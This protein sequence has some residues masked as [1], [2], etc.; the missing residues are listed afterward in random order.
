MTMKKKILLL[1]GNS[2]INRAFYALPIL[3][4][5]DGTYTNAVYGFLNI[6]FKLFDEDKPD[7]A[8]V[9]FD[10]PAP[11][12]RHKQFGDY[13]GDRKPMPQEL[14]P[15]IGTLKN[16]LA[17]MNV[18][19][20]EMEGFEAD[21][22][23]GTLAAKSLG[24]GLAPVIV[25]GDRDMLQLCTDVLEVRIPRTKAGKTEVE[26]YFAQDVKERIGV[27]PTEYIDVKALM[28]DASDNIPGVAGIG[29]KTAVKLVQ[30]HGS[31]EA[32]IRASK[33]STAAKPT[34]VVQS[35]RDNEEIALLSK[36]LATIVTD[37]P[38][39]FDLAETGTDGFYNAVSRAEILRLGFK[40]Y[41]ERFATHTPALAKAESAAGDASGEEADAG[42]T[43]IDTPEQLEAFARELSASD[44]VAYT[45]VVDDDGL[46]GFSISC[47]AQGS[48]FVRICESL[49]RGRVLEI[50]AP[51]F[52]S[53][54]AKAVP[55]FK[56]ELGL[57][58]GAG[59][60]LRGVR[61]DA[62]LAAYVA[63]SSKA[64][65]SH[66]DIALDILG[67]HVRTLEDVLGKGKARK[68]LAEADAQE[69]T[70]VVCNESRVVLKAAPLLRRQMADNGQQ[71]LYDEM[72]L[73][74][75]R[76][77]HD[78]EVHGIRVSKEELESFGRK[79]DTGISELTADIYD[80]AEE[81]F[82]INSPAQLG[83][84]LFEKLGLKG[85]KKT[86]TG[87]S[88]AA[89]VLE[90]LE[91][92][93]P[94]VGRV[95]AYRTY[96]KLKSTYVDG[97]IPL[98][99]ADTGKLHSTFSQTVAS[100]GRISSHEPNLQNI[101][102]RLELGRELRKAFIP[103]GPEYVFLDGDYNQIELRVLAHLSG[104]ETLIQ[105]F[106]EDQD[107]HRLTASQVF[108]T[109][110]DL[111]TPGQRSAAKAVNFGIVYG[112]GAYS[113]S[114]DLKIS[115]KEAESYIAG[116]F[117]RYPRVKV[118][119]DAAVETARERGFAA[120]LFGR[121]R[122]IPELNSPNFNQ[123]AFGERAAMN[124]PIQG[125]AADIIKIAMVRVHKSLTERGLR[126]RL[127]LQVHDEL[128]LEAHRDELDEVRGILRQEMEGSAQMA[129]P[130]V[131]SFH[132]GESWYD[133]K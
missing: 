64:S 3:T 63:D 112:M 100:T 29:E 61:F 38:I 128:L 20:F 31:L 56:R 71:E 21:D 55:D 6:F 107:I 78:M 2:L 123:R 101:P 35:L 30:E 33:E 109:H 58:R 114:Q 74:L 27:T 32:A 106:N 97:L 8:A 19:T 54:Q 39:S 22:L 131:C 59:T 51:F 94:I 65:Y 36:H 4:T 5:P 104:D 42:C 82:N 124:M 98:I 95:L 90:K 86:K 70:R 66:A 79:L 116:Y 43:L 75:A 92:K 91:A 93:H 85:S 28:G 81:E 105:A 34:K 80:L 11:T 122:P 120:T 133:A 37:A 12:F 23:L 57:L 117:A 45:S 130:L 102:V 15:Q 88:T 62:S 18:K 53:E 111:V 10:L 113:L 25:S 13:K 49:P 84:I 89:D 126:S 96:A 16:L 132:T 108:N 115:V 118:F 77:L 24:L 60:E 50:L 87:Y 72:E 68:K 99:N 46:A 67:E 17:M 76:V 9:A 1:D 121:R 73:P 47:S 48:V 26:R 41:F 125:T 83:A 52:A 14:R 119:M 7:F 103:S 40:S 44:M 129:V 127:I 69:I 110:F